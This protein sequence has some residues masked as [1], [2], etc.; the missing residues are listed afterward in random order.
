M[1]TGDLD[2]QYYSYWVI[3]D[4]LVPNTHSKIEEHTTAE[5]GV[6]VFSPLDYDDETVVAGEKDEEKGEGD[7]GGLVPL[8][9]WTGGRGGDDDRHVL[10]SPGTDTAW[11]WG[12]PPTAPPGT[13]EKTWYAREGQ[14]FIERLDNPIQNPYE[15]R[16]PRQFLPEDVN[17]V[18]EVGDLNGDGLNDLV[19][20]TEKGTYIS[21]T[22]DA[23]STTN[24]YHPPVLL[25]NV[26]EDI[27]DVVT[28]D[29]NK[30]GAQ[31]LV[32]L[33][34]DET[35]PNRIYYGD[36]RDPEM[37]NLG[38]KEHETGV[39]ENGVP[40]EPVGGL[41]YAP[42]GFDGV[43]YDANGVADERDPRSAACRP[44]PSSR[45]PRWWGST[46]TATASTTPSW[47]SPTRTTAAAPARRTSSTLWA[48]RRPSRSRART[49]APPTWWPCGSTATPTSP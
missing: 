28:L 44:R 47:W 14:Q 15:P 46:P 49:R 31:D 2:E 7:G 23:Y 39:T 8:S 22:Y 13:T 38:E 5:Q 33:T 36:S 48:Q 24:R 41:R 29:Y 18:V 37:K 21:L 27:T 3:V 1:P 16:D 45:A 11:V 32:L 17:R 26:V 43:T 6:S 4:F 30:D 20:L 9:P 10:L 34:R 42:L 25:S 40:G 35:K 19:Y 12:V